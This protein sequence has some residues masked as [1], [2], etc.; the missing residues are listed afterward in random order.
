MEAE[1]AL[2]QSGKSVREDRQRRERWRFAVRVTTMVVGLALLIAIVW[3]LFRGLSRNPT[4]QNPFSSV[5]FGR[6]DDGPDSTNSTAN[7][8]YHHAMLLMRGDDSQ[9]L[10]EVYTELTDATRRDPNFAKAYAALFE[11]RIREH[12]SGLPPVT[13]EELRKRTD[14]LWELAPRMAATHVARSFMEFFDCH[15][16]AAIR[17]CETAIIL[18]PRYEFAHSHLGMMLI[19]SGNPNEAQ[20]QLL[21]ALGIEDSKAVIRGMLGCVDFER[22][23]FENAITQQNLALRFKHD[24]PAAYYWIG[25]SFQAMTNYPEAINAFQMSE[26]FDGANTNECKASFDE[27]LKAYKEPWGAGVLENIT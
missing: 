10:S 20:K 3:G 13:H 18:N 26:I 22:R 24:Y 25:R 6:F 16:D 7:A 15:Y 12:V 19:L 27:L 14:N 17:E 1:L 8:L 11:F 5:N 9:Q 4:A 21:T 2:L 23:D